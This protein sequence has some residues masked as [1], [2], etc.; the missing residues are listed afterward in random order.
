VL[1]VV[2]I[3]VG[4]NEGFV[5]FGMNGS[6]FVIY[7]KDGANEGAFEGDDVVFTEPVIGEELVVG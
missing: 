3:S 4:N 6:E 7:P 1:Y 2:G 5:V